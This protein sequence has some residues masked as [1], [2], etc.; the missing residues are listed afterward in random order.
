MG[1]PRVVGALDGRR[2]PVLKPVQR[3]GLVLL[4]LIEDAKIPPTVRHERNYG[5]ER[6]SR[7][8]PPVYK[9]AHDKTPGPSTY[10]QKL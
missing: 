1:W 9:A 3:I 6:Q 5:N 2:P 7:V 8:K 10:H 4:P